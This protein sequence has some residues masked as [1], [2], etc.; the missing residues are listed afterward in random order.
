M[1][2]TPL[3]DAGSRVLIVGAGGFG[4]EIFA[5]LADAIEDG[6]E[7]EFGGFLDGNPDALG[8][9]SAIGTVLGAP[10][11][12]RVSRHD[13]FLMGI[14]TPR[15]KLPL[16]RRMESAGARFLTL[17]HPNARIGP[18]STLGRGSVLCPGAIVTT[19]VT[20]GEFCMLNVAA[21]VGHDAVLGAGCT[22]S[23]HS[24]VTGH[25]MLGE[26]V[27]LGSH[28]VILPGVEVGAWATVGAGS[29]AVRRVESNSTVF[30]VPAR[31]IL[32][33]QAKGRDE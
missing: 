14:G 20:I 1:A 25:A 23:G 26:G 22:L 33:Q 9:N 28:A 5:W 11:T 29:V 19:D 8:Q 31:V 21:T 7:V 27:F 4:R 6:L 17:V 15:R 10:E 13:R 24:D 16:A 30:G 18:R 2:A 32:E 3:A 12:F